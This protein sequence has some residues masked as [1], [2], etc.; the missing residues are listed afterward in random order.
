MTRSWRSRLVPWAVPL[1][2]ANLWG[3]CP[4]SPLEALSGAILLQERVDPNAAP[5]DQTLAFSRALDAMSPCELASL[6]NFITAGDWTEADALTVQNVMA[7]VDAI[8][9][10]QLSLLT[11]DSDPTAQEIQ[12]AFA[13]V[14][15]I[16][17]IETAELIKE[18]LDGFSQFANT[19]TNGGGGGL[20][21]PWPLPP[22]P[23][24]PL[25]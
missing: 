22:L 4:N 2:L 18:M 14:L 15:I 21:P 3:C 11:S 5:A 25:L 7:Q 10:Q 8:K 1:M 16:I 24:P 20:L 23:M 17:P 13:S 6:V 9:A 12:T 19:S